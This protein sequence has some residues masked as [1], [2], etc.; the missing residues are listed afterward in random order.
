VSF[1][2]RGFRDWKSLMPIELTCSNCNKRLRVPDK[3]AGRRVRCPNCEHVVSV[4]ADE[5]GSSPNAAQPADD[6][7][8]SGWSLQT[9][10]SE[11][12][13][14]VPKSELDGWYHEGRITADCQLLLEGASQ[15]QWATDV[16]PDLAAGASSAGGDASSP[17]AIEADTSA[18]TRAGGGKQGR[19][20]TNQRSGSPPNYLP[21]AIFSLI[22]GCLP[23][24]IPALI[25]AV[26]A[27]S[28]AAHGDDIGAMKAASSAKMLCFLAIGLQLLVTMLAIAF[29][30]AISMQQ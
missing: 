30:V 19:A 22:C 7:E 14:P 23:L 21:L 24:G 27:N 18:T 28:K 6:N 2:V 20:P 11:Q 4:P 3:A 15:W 13:G 1:A 9:E 16:Y 29:Q 26:Q 8:T 12:Y 25:F 17:F 10:E 5:G